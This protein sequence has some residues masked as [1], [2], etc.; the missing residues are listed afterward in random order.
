MNKHIHYKFICIQNNLTQFFEKRAKRF[1]IDIL[2]SLFLLKKYRI[3]MLKTFK[4]KN[5]HNKYT[6]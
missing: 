3:L 5:P 6:N 1:I 4:H 2:A